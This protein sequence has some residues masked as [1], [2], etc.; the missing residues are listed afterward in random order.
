MN[1]VRI[2]IKR[3]QS[4]CVG[5]NIKRV[6]SECGRTECIWKVVQSNGRWESIIRK[7]Y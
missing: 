6:Q 1:V 4:E 7:E 2:N 3:V 5:I